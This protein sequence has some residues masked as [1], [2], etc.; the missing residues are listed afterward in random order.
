MM[1]VEEIEVKIKE[2]KAALVKL[3]EVYEKEEDGDKINKLQYS[4]SRKEEN[5]DKLIERQQSLL[6]REK[7][8]E[9]KET[10][11]DKDAEEE[12]EDVCPSCGADLNQIGEDENGVAI[13]E[14]PICH[15]L[16]LDE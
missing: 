6:D 16:F 13:F 1:N 10:P 15:E 8:D 7:E 5:I 12:D 4:I 9:E 3:E 14:C 2:E 11:K